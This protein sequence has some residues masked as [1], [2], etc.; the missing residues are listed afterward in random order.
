MNIRQAIANDAERLLDFLV[1]FRADGCNTV[2]NR[3]SLPNLQQERDWL[4]KRTGEDAVVFVAERNGKIVG[5][6][7]ATVPNA[8]EFRHTCEFGISVLLAFRKQGIGKK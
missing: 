2:I 4:S 1:A 5:I 7:E 3:S 6:I 8:A